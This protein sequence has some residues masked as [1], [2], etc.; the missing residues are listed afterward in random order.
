MSRS[1]YTFTADSPNKIYTCNTY[2]PSLSHKYGIYKSPHDSGTLDLT[3]VSLGPVSVG[4]IISV[5]FLLAGIV[6]LMVGLLRLLEWAMEEG[7]M[8]RLWALC[9][10]ACEGS[11]RRVRGLRRPERRRWKF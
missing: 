8:T 10:G 4:N 11:W 1:L 9:S 7:L 2:R 6:G 3:S 5:I